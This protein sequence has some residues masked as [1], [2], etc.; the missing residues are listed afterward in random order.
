VI[1]FRELFGVGVLAHGSAPG[2]VNLM[3]DH[4]D[5]NDG[6]VLPAAIPQRTTV[7]I[8]IADAT[9]SEVYSHTLR[10]RISFDI[11]RGPLPGFSK[12]VGGCLR[13]LTA[14]GIALPALKIAVRSEVPVGMGLSSS[15]ALEV[16][17]LRSLDKGF[18]LGLSDL[19]IAEL[20]WKAET[21]HAG[22]NCG[23]MDQIACAVATVDNMLFLDT[24]T[25]FYRSVPLPPDA[26]I[27][28][29]DSGVSRSLAASGYNARRR[30]C[31]AAA[32]LLGVKS[33]RDVSS[34]TAAD[35]L[36]PPLSGR[37]RHVVTENARVQQA[38]TADA[39]TFGRLMNESHA[40]L[41]DDYEV[42][43]PLV[44]ALVAT[45]QQ[46]PDVL[47]ARMTGAGFG[48]A[49]VALARPSSAEALAENF[50]RTSPDAWIVTVF[51]RQS[52]LGQG[53]TA[54]VISGYNRL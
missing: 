29:V 44:D 20:A 10:Q 27:L 36:P 25:R 9:Q 14:R 1:P 42:S 22:V 41:R 3:G 18:A 28:V 45:L 21:G 40:S 51:S 23:I 2:R 53:N 43:H 12:F 32:T 37:V 54:G 50:R 24:L 38:L 52:P 26:D 17:T 31:E 15:A 5:Y 49:C 30:E 35:G 4:T 47:G 8:A 19:D 6:F 11:G 16:A 48:G 33:L 39:M 34:A 7:E 46:S 13:V